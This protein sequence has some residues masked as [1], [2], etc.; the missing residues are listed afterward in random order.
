MWADPAVTPYIGGGKPSTRE[1]SWARLLRYGGLWPLVGFGYWV[2]E[3]KTTRR[4]AG[5]AGFADFKRAL[6]P[7]FG[8]A[9]EAGWVLASWAHGHGFAT[10]AVLAAL[11]WADANLSSPRTVCMI[12]PQN[13]AS[14]NV[15]KK[16]GYREFARATFRE[17]PTVLF[18]RPRA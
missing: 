11:A 7:S 17:T 13:A 3:E 2:I 6:E 1:E 14:I 16:S 9:P 12:D 8:D 15:A 4:F 5:E 18:E 10:E